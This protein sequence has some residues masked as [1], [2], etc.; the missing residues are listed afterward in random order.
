MSKSILVVGATGNYAQPVVWQ[1]SK[2]GFDVRVFTRKREK[3]VKFFGEAFPIF[4]GNIEDDASL[5]KAL[6]GCWGV[7]INM[8]GWWKDHSHDRLEHRGTANV[9]RLAKEAGVQR[10]TYL[11]DVHACETY[12]S[13]PHLKA[14]IDAEK[15]IRES[16]IP[17]AVFGC[18]FF[19]EGCHH[20]EK[21]D[22]IRVPVLRQPYHYVAAA[23]YALM[24]SKAYQAAEAPNR[25]IDVYGPDAIPAHQA[26]EEFIATVR[27]GTKIIPIPLWIATI[28]MYLV[29]HK[30]RQYSMRVVKMYKKH[31]EPG[32]PNKVDPVVGKPTT[33]FR[34]W[35]K[36]QK[37]Q[38]PQSASAG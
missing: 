11:S 18:S 6:E 28:Y 5:R 16:G 21:G 38:F 4:E 1:L 15:A 9:V 19:M 31:G 12:S 3:A 36:V 10:L 17:F 25:R 13:L 23:D 14:K 33:R 35:C 32:D 20:L 29:R 30:N 8:R 34:D 22:V 24:V 7:H 26:T 37:P 2:D 27:P